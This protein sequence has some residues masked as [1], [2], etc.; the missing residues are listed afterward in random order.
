MKRVV[1]KN[2][3]WS[4]FAA[5]RKYARL[6]FS[7]IHRTISQN[8]AEGSHAAKICGTSSLRVA[9]PYFSSYD[10]VRQNSIRALTRKQTYNKAIIYCKQ[11]QN[12]A[13]LVRMSTANYGATCNLIQLHNAE[14]MSRCAE[15]FGGG[16]KNSSITSKHFQFS[17]K[18]LAI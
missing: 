11:R 18:E 17:W 6:F 1:T 9:T 14:P 13:T 10:G 15:D 2:M 16:I 7:T 3:L 5:R 8:D 4:K 12:S